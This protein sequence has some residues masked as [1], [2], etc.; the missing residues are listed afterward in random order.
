ML[1]AKYRER[2]KIYIKTMSEIVSVQCICN[3]SRHAVHYE[4]P[5]NAAESAADRVRPPL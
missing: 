3:H 1:Q 2:Q 4:H 5:A